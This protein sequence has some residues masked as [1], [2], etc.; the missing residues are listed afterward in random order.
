MY[1]ELT[2]NNIIFNDNPIIIT[3]AAVLKSSQIHAALN[4]QT[5]AVL[6]S[7]PRQTSSPKKHIS[8]TSPEPHHEFIHICDSGDH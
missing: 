2:E 6:V 4:T 8:T 5:L 7:T 3:H 1:F